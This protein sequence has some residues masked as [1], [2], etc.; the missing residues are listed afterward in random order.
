MVVAAGVDPMAL[1]SGLPAFLHEGGGERWILSRVVLFQNTGCFAKLLSTDAVEQLDGWEVIET[2]YDP[3]LESVLLR[4]QQRAPKIERRTRIG[5]FEC[6]SHT[7]PAL[8]NQNFSVVSHDAVVED[9]VLVL[10]FIGTDV[11]VV[12]LTLVFLAD[13]EC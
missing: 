4:E 8:C 6:G 12:D 3:I 7:S 1:R 10:G 13:V 5:V 9:V 11:E 2:V